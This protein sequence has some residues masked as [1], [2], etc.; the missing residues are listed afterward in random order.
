MVIM[1]FLKETAAAAM[2]AAIAVTGASTAK[3][4]T[5]SMV[6]NFTGGVTLDATI[7]TSNTPDPSYSGGYDITGITGVITGLPVGGGITQSSYTITGLDLNGEIGGG[8]N[9]NPID[10]VL[11][12]TGPQY[13]DS[14]GTAFNLS[15]SSSDLIGAGLWGGYGDNSAT[16][17]IGNWL[18]GSAYSADGSLTVSQAPLPPAWTAMLTGLAV[19]GFVAYRQNRKGA[20]PQAA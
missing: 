5:Y 12:P 3:A 19:L 17:F 2:V 7:T 15:P 8:T 14:L 18:W 1:S 11:F 13:L 6:G 10:N 4:N 20:L 16:L 9:V